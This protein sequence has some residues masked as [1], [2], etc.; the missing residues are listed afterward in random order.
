MGGGIHLLAVRG[1]TVYDQG[2]GTAGRRDAGEPQRG[3]RKGRGD[4]GIL[5]T[6]DSSELG[7]LKFARS[8]D[9]FTQEACIFQ[10]ERNW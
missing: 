9:N 10:R 5:R 3:I 1:I 6:S 8:A 7:F 2:R 4:P